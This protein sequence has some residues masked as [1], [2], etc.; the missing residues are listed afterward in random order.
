M[1]ISL[2]FALSACDTKTTIK[3]SCGDGFIDPGEE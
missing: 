2:L 3:D 1:T